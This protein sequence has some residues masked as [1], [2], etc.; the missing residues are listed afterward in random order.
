MPGISEI[1]G[2]SSISK[3]LVCYIR[4]STKPGSLEGQLP[5]RR[6]SS[7]SSVERGVAKP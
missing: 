4:K 6:R 1:S 3:S 2:R 5:T 7:S